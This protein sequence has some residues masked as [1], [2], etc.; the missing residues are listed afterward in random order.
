M[1][2]IPNTRI[3]PTHQPGRDN[4][5]ARGNRY[6]PEQRTNIITETLERRTAGED[7]EQIASAHNI[8]RATL[9]TWLGSI[10]DS[11]IEARRAWIEAKLAAAE[12]GIETADDQLSATRARMRAD[13][14]RWY[15]ER[16][17]PARYA[18]KQQVDGSVNIQVIVER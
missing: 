2:T 15:A 12:E 10:P 8:T 7:L 16:R 6:T 1:P 13:Y 9:R 4:V 11:A 3:A 5:P 14:W 17:D 18:A